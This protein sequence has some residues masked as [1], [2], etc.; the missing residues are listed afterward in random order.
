MKWPLSFVFHRRTASFR[1]QIDEN[2]RSSSGPGLRLIP[3]QRSGS[4]SRRA[5]CRN[6]R[7]LVRPDESEFVRLRTTARSLSISESPARCSAVWATPLPRV[8][9]A[10]SRQAQHRSGEREHAPVSAEVALPRRS[11]PDQPEFDAPAPPIRPTSA[12]APGRSAAG[13]RSGSAVARPAASDAR[14]EAAIPHHRAAWCR[15]HRRKPA[16]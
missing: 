12:S 16:A 14:R 10:S 8:T 15:K 13:L 11:S 7:I 3:G 5:E 2:S 6:R 1:R 4:V 9:P